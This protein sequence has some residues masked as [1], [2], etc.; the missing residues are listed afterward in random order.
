M[1]IL[2]P[3]HT[4]RKRNLNGGLTSESGQ[5]PVHLLEYVYPLPL[6]NLA[7]ENVGVQRSEVKGVR[8]KVCQ[9]A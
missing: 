1:T 6:P 5:L 7:S 9:S 8:N 4:V 2:A 3:G